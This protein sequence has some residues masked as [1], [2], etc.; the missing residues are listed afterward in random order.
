MGIETKGPLVR[1][2]NKYIRFIEAAVPIIQNS[3][4]PLYSCKYSKKVYTQHQLLVLLL[5]KEYLREDYRDIVEMV[6]LMT[7]VRE[8]LE[9][10]TVPH[11]TT[12]QKFMTRIRSF[13]FHVLLNRIL[14]LFYSR[15]EI[16]PITAID[17]SGFTSSYASSYYSWRT[18]KTRKRFIKTS[19]SIDTGKQV[20][21]GWKLSQHP[22]HDRAH[23]PLLLKGCHRMRRS[24]TYVLDKGY[25]A[26][27]IHRLIR[28]DLRAH[29][30]IPVRDRKRK[31]VGGKYRKKMYRSF[32]PFV[33]HRRNLAE[34]VFSVLKRRFGESLKARKYWN[35]VKEIKVKVVIYNLNRWIGKIW[36]IVIRGILQSLRYVYRHVYVIK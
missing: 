12:L 25:D 10:E 21:T 9:L 24:S 19:L 4:I 34:T 13:L 29:S 22:A 15:G 1:L 23:A 8:I 16:I 2:S 33:Y 11:F 3:R 18:G 31:R 35:Q 36:F 27:E 14:H 17:S 5:F 30:E 32:D 28:E 20:I 26:E 6:D 7:S